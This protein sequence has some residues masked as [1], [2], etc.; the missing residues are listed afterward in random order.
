M[1]TS[2]VNPINYILPSKE[3][4]EEAPETRMSKW[5]RITPTGLQD[6]KCDPK[7]TTGVAMILILR[8]T[9]SSWKKLFKKNRK[10]SDIVFL[11]WIIA[12]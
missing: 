9:L 4:V 6:Y 7:V 8:C 5:P 1:L 11:V 12:I 10:C 2:M 3:P